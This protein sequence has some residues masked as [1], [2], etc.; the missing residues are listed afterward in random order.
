MAEKGAMTVKEAG[1]RGGVSTKKRH[2][3]EF[4][5]RIGKQGGETT[6]AA[7]G[8]GLLPEDREEGREQGEAA[9]RAGEAGAEGVR[10]AGES[11]WR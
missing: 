11:R 10:H 2:G 1:R 7:H 4:Y 8:T 3:P 9:D 6:K 5:Q